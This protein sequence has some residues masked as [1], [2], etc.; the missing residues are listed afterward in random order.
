MILYP[1][2]SYKT[3]PVLTILV[4]FPRRAVLGLSTFQ[5]H[6][7]RKDWRL[8]RC[9]KVSECCQLTN[10]FASCSVMLCF[11]SF[12]FRLFFSSPSP[13]IFQQKHDLFYQFILRRFSGVFR[14][15][16]EIHSID[17]RK[18]LSV[19]YCK[20]GELPTRLG[21][22]LTVFLFQ[23]CNHGQKIVWDKFKIQ[24]LTW[25]LTTVLQI[26][27]A[28]PPCQGRFSEFPTLIEGRG[29]GGGGGEDAQQVKIWGEMNLSH[30]SF[31]FQ[32]S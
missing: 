13:A 6:V 17:D 3:Q 27:S 26:P 5:L 8:R 16:S 9:T 19:V 20:N 21:G 10:E 4:L 12:S 31:D 15:K 7:L 23:S 29:T 28:S 25:D 2:T 22:K 11:S 1:F 32:P 24:H 18:I 30:V 14:L